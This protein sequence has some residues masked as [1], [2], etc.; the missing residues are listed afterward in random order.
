MTDCK[1]IRA[2]S[3]GT[4]SG[5]ALRETLAYPAKVHCYR[6]LV[7]NFFRREFF[8]RFKGSM[9]G[10]GWVMIEPVT[11]F[12]I[13]FF[14][15]GL[16][17]NMRAMEGMPGD[18]YPFYLFSGVVSWLIFANTTSMGLATAVENGNLIKKVAF[19][20]EL[21]PFSLVL[22][23]LIVLGVGTGILGVS[24]VAWALISPETAP[25]QSWPGLKLLLLVPLSL[26]VALFSLGFT[27]LLATIYVFLRDIHQIWN[28][29]MLFWFFATPI[30]WHEGMLKN[31]PS[32]QAMKSFMEINPYYHFVQGYRSC[33]GL[34]DYPAAL[35]GLGVESAAQVAGHACL[36][37]FLPSLVVFLVGCYFF[38]LFKKRF[39]DEV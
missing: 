3:L 22:V 24:A 4:E 32:Y 35:H 7:A 9:L 14:V 27:L 12:F 16:L 38:N 11:L 5:R 29:F 8:G 2:D 1:E 31:S 17:F 34:Y 13:Y 23:N 28:V 6:Y 19:P 39:A 10:V 15:F 26:E 36:V 20:A 37:G 30:F 18:W 21:L 25:I 33:L